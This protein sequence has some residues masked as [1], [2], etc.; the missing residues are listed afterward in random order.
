[1][2]SQP[3]EKLTVA[4]Y[5]ASERLSEIRHQYFRGKVFAMVGA[6]NN[7]NKITA[8]LIVMSDYRRYFFKGGTYFFTIVTHGQRPI[9][10]TEI[11]RNLLRGSIETIRAKRPFKI[12]ATVLLPDHWHL[13]M[14]LPPED[15][16][17]SI[18]LKRIKEE[19]TTAWLGAGQSE[20]KV[21]PAQRKKGDRGIWQPRFWEHLILDEDDL[22]ACVDYIHWNPRKH[23][24]TNRIRDWHWSSYH[25]FVRSGDYPLN[26]GGELPRSLEQRVSDSWGEAY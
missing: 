3:K 14:R 24:L 7:H 20:A 25:R 23:K 11:G 12:I 4:Q 2:S 18:R 9:L 1:M 15:D 22:I 21:T 8:H 6:S 16:K 5:I 10:T 19:F 13:V 17:Y 26:W